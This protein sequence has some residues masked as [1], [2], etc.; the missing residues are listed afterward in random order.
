MLQSPDKVLLK[1][2]VDTKKPNILA[3]WFRPPV[4]CVQKEEF[5]LKLAVLLT[6]KV[7]TSGLEE[8]SN[9]K[10][11][12][13]GNPTQMEWIPYTALR[14]HISKVTCEAA[15]PKGSV[16]NPLVESTT[17]KLA[18]S[19]TWATWNKKA[20]N[21]PKTIWTGYH[22]ELGTRK[23]IYITRGTFHDSM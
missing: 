2:V 1:C 10:K 20:K 4:M 15:H 13:S 21:H 8:F 9:Q 3:W 16:G 14:S 19:T 11:P 17:G 23:Y 12:Y 18:S 22:K 5:G 7:P 6:W